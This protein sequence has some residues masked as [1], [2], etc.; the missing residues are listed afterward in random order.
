MHLLARVDHGVEVA[1]NEVLT[2][3]QVVAEELQH[4]LVHDGRMEHAPD[5]GHHQYNKRE[6]GEN[7]VGGD[8]ECKSMHIGAHQ[9]LD[10]GKHQPGRPARGR[11]A[12]GGLSLGRSRNG[13][14]RH[15]EVAFIVT[16][17][18]ISLTKVGNL[19]S[20][21]VTGYFLILVK[22]IQK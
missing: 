19:V 11:A 13:R 14:I 17:A 21:A 2:R 20:G 4:H 7:R 18:P 9:V 5:H 1:N 10:R 12:W 16:E 15:G 3:G 8:R 22:V 6:E